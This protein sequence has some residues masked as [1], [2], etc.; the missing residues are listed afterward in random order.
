[1]FA[2]SGVC[3]SRRGEKRLTIWK[4]PVHVL[5]EDECK[6]TIEKENE[7]KSTHTHKEGASQHKRRQ[8]NESVCASKEKKSV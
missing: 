1:M 2:I 5:I 6:S 8:E 4:I 3:V 7:R